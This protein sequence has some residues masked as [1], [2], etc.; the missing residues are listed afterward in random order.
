MVG[1][2]VHI[3]RVSKVMTI[4]EYFFCNKKVSCGFKVGKG[5]GK[6]SRIVLSL[7]SSGNLIQGENCYHFIGYNGNLMVFHMRYH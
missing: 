2:D 7:I 5:F 6:N 1:K 4:Y 3:H